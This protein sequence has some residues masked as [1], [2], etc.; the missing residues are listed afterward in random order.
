[1]ATPHNYSDNI[2][3]IDFG[4]GSNGKLNT[5]SSSPSFFTERDSLIPVRR[6]Y[7][8]AAEDDGYVTTPY[9]ALHSP[10]SGGRGLTRRQV[11]DTEYS[12]LSDIA[13]LEVSNEDGTPNVISS[14]FESFD[15]DECENSLHKKKM[16]YTSGEKY[17][18]MNLFRWIIMLVIGILTAMVAV[19][20][21]ICIDQ[22]SDW[23][24]KTIKSQLDQC[25]DTRCLALPYCMWVGL[26]CAF[27]FLATLMVVYAEPVAAGSGIPQIK[28]FLNGVKIPHVVRIKTLVTKVS[29]VV[30]SVVWCGVVW[31]GV[32]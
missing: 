7:M 18:Q 8:A 22:M 11:I 12:G 27:V 5:S 4:G 13:N 23:K 21:D 32:V 14:K 25:L 28:C 19:C 30:F 17:I 26:N 2:R 6:S 3:L 15:Y 10:K 24:Y 29:G 31:C 16:Q 9:V 20:I 1:M